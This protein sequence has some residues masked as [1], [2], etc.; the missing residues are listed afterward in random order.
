MKTRTLL[1]TI[2]SFPFVLCGCLVLLGEGA[3]CRGDSPTSGMAGMEAK[4]IAEK[5]AITAAVAH[6]KD[7]G[8]LPTDYEAEAT[9]ETKS[10][11]WLV[12]ISTRPAMP[13][14]HVGVKVNSQGVVTG[15]IPGE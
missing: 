10:G 6:L 15:I 1:E 13:G 4:P 8:T 3:G 14:G 12:I 9:R 2:S 11:E 7:I 5:D